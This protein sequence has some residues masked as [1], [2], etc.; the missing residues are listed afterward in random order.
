MKNTKA[1]VAATLRLGE[2]LSDPHMAAIMAAAIE[3]DRY[4]WASV[5]DMERFDGRRPTR[6]EVEAN[7]QL[8]YNSGMSHALKNTIIMMVRAGEGVT[9]LAAHMVV[10]DEIYNAVDAMMTGK[11]ASLSKFLETYYG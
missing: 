4:Y 6:A 3:W 7:G 1:N 2:V 11:G 5:S 8:N 9:R 10:A